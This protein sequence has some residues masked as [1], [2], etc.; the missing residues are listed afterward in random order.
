MKKIICV[1]NASKDI[2][3]PIK[4]A[5]VID[6]GGKKLLAFEYKSKIQIE[7]RYEAPGGCAVNLSQ[8]I[9]KFGVEAACYCRIGN[10][11]DGD[12]IA[13][14]LESADV[15]ISLVQRDKDYKTD[16]AVIVVNEAESESTIIFNRDA[17]EQLEIKPEEINA[18]WVFVASSLSGNWKEN[19]D[20]IKIEVQKKG[21]KLAYNPGQSNIHE[22]VEKVKSFM[23]GAEILFVNKNEAKTILGESTEDATKLLEKLIALGV[24]RV[25]ITDGSAGAYASNGSVSFFVPAL[26]ARAVDSAGA[27]DAFSSAFF[28]GYIQGKNLDECLKR[29]IVNGS[30]VVSFYGA[31]KGL[32]DEAEM[33]KKIEKIQAE[34]I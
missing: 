6:S 15:D 24:K 14:N 10:D 9:S 2:F 13:K 1:G 20:K 33:V 30:S 17:N 4:N 28:V 31:Q 29:G 8:G 7:N 3:F 19:L 27:G 34:E 26:E 18:E 11:P 16:L 32:L 23:T 5:T 21:I 12:W 25:V 22:D